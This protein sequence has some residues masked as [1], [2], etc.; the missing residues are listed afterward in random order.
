MVEVPYMCTICKGELQPSGEELRCAACDL[1][2]QSKGGLFDFTA[3]PADASVIKE[4]SLKRAYSA[5]F[6]LIAPIYESWIWYQLTLNLSGAGDSSIA[7]IARFVGEAL[8]NTSG[9]ILDV[10]CGT[11]TYGRRIASSSRRI[12]GVDLSSGMLRRGSAFLA[13][14]GIDNVS[15]ARATVERLPFGDAAFDGAICCGSLHLF[16]DPLIALREIARTLKAKA[17]LA[18][19]TFQTGRKDG[20]NTL[21]DKIGYHKYEAEELRGRLEA[22]GFGEIGIKEVGTVLLAKARKI[23]GTR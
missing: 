13:R 1:S 2:F 5:F 15:L 12:Y 14:E 6:N 17:P 10:A 9:S 23:D 7:S 21:N 18:L 3:L 16:P 11:A 22:A 19:Q 4:S 20:A 8:G